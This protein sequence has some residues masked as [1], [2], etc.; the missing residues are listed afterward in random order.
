VLARRLLDEMPAHAG[1][2]RPPVLVALFGLPGAGK[3]AVAGYLAARLPL[4]LLA[5]DAIR[6]R[7]GLP[8]GPAAHA[9][10]Y[11]VAAVLLR[12]GGGVLWDGIHLTRAHRD[13][14]RAFAAGHGARLELLW[15]TADDAVVSARLREREADP[16]GTAADGKFV[17]PSTKLAQLAAWL[18]P[19]EPDESVTRVDTSVEP[20]GA[21]LE[22]LEQRLARLIV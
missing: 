8:S 4:T 16:A 10:I 20:V 18:E 2:W 6:L 19:P 21:G 12:D 9:V 22:A 17:I 13:A 14:L 3:S 11:E 7:H 5:T 1:R 15:C